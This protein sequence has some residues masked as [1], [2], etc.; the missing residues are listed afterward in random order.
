MCTISGVYTHYFR[1]VHTLLPVCTH[2]I[3][4]VYTHYFRCVHTLLPVCTHTIAGVYTHVR[5]GNKLQQLAIK[6]TSRVSYQINIYISHTRTHAHTHTRT[7]THAHTTAVLTLYTADMTT[8]VKP[9][10]CAA[11][12]V[13]SIEVYTSR[14]HVCMSHYHACVCHMITY[15]SRVYS[16]SQ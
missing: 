11:Y 2:T 9:L 16:N 1:C 12:S 13:R 3:A 5:C 6:Q 14:G 7:H 15:V 8:A 10:Q 4:G